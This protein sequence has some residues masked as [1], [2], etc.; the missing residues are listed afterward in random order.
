MTPNERKREFF[1]EAAPDWAH[2]AFDE[3]GLKVA[4]W[5][6]EMAG[7]QPGMTVLEPGC[8]A[9]RMTRLLAR[10]VGPSGR[11][12][13]CDISER[14]LEAARRNVPGSN[15]E[16]HAVSAEETELE[17][18]SL[19]AVLCF[20]VFPHFDDPAAL[21]DRLHRALKPGGQLIVAHHPGRHEVNE[22]HMEAGGAVGA[23]RLPHGDEMRQLF[24]DRGYR[25]QRLLDQSDRYFLSAQAAQ[26]AQGSRNAQTA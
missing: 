6:V 24:R 3:E 5:I 18:N 10:A 17:E 13:A 20:D 22:I 2:G 21:L 12:I 19:D 4:R 15:V 25:I 1:D 9:G 16:F 11:V 14:M 7:I 8:G 26:A 23:D